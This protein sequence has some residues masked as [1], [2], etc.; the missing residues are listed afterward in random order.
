MARRS[1]T[2][3]SRIWAAATWDTVAAK[4]FLVATG[5]VDPK[6]VGIFGG[7]YGGFM[8]LM[9]IGRAPDEFA[10]AVQCVRHHQLADDVPR[11]KDELLKA[12]QRGL[13]GTPESDPAIR[14]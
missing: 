7:S 6:R 8:T 12:Y 1:R 5:Y 11:S 3:T 14:N 10:A 13:L 4:A 9:A 2:P